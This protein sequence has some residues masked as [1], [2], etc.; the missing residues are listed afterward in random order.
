MNKFIPVLGVLGIGGIAGLGTALSHSM[1]DKETIKDKLLKEG[2]K[3]LKEDGAEWGKILEAYKNDKNVWKLKKEHSGISE[4]IQ[5]EFDLKAACKTVV[6]AE[7][8][9]K[10][11]YKS[12]TKWCV[13]PRKAEEFVTGLL[14]VDANNTNDTSAWQH[15]IDG[16]KATHQSSGGKYEWSDV[17]FENNGNAEDLKKLKNG[18]KTRRDKLTYDVEFDTTISEINKW[19]LGKKS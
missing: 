12:V 8:S 15:N 9:I 13:V 14:G 19:C 5:N 10:E 18:C 2:Y 17:S 6:K 4:D 7:S 11:L 1:S 3:L 16:Y